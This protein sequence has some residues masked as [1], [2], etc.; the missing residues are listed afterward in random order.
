VD[1]PMKKIYGVVSVS[2]MQQSRG[3]YTSLFGREPDLSPMPEVHEWYVGNGGLQVVDDPRRSG[4]SMLTII[5]DDL[6]R[7]RVDLQARKL[8]LGASS[9]G[10]FATVAQIS[11]PDGNQITFAQPGP[12]QKK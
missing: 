4:Q 9:G 12:A 1:D 2:N 8:T 6:E 11:D 10:D 3:W 7:I 5:V